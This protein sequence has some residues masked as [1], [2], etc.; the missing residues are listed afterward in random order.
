[1]GTNRAPMKVLKVLHGISAPSRP[2]PADLTY[3]YAYNCHARPALACLEGAHEVA[4]EH[5]SY[6][7][8]AETGEERMPDEDWG[9]ELDLS[10]SE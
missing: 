9:D 4:P 7:V 3:S 10:K 1:M 2:S 8:A 5:T 6:A